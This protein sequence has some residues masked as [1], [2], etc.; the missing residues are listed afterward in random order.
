MRDRQLIEDCQMVFGL[1]ALESS[2]AITVE[3]TNPDYD[4]YFGSIAYSKGGC[5][6]RMAENFMTEEKF[7]QGV[8]AYLKEY[9]YGN[10]ETAQLW[11]KLTEFA[12][13]PQG[14]NVSQIM[15]T[16]TT[17]PGFPVV[18][19]NAT[20]MSQTR[21]LLDPNGKI[22]DST[23]GVESYNLFQFQPRIMKVYG[24]F[25]SA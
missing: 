13:L 10:A 19:I 24:R 18:T 23:F 9:L 12:D 16:W 22:L 21:F 15:N 17:Q 4:A 7:R 11:A 3:V 8:N 20:Q 25:Q 14:L 2:K 5:L 6:L 1:D